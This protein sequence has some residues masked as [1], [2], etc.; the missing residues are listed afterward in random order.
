MS[1]LAFGIVKEFFK[2]PFL[3][4][5]LDDPMTVADFKQQLESK[6]PELKKLQSY[7]IA[8]NEEYADDKE[9]LNQGDV[10]AIIPPVSGG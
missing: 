9:R 10:I 5:E 2:A 4:I 1:I 7:M 6:Y 3:N 8:K